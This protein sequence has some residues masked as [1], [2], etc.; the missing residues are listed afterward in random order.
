P[1]FMLTPSRQNLASRNL[2]LCLSCNRDQPSA[3]GTSF[4]NWHEPPSKSDPGLRLRVSLQNLASRY[5]PPSD[6]AEAAGV[7]NKKPVSARRLSETRRVRDAPRF[8][9]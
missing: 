7:R 6:W 8:D 4:H 1:G 2:P 9:E 3:S 5:L